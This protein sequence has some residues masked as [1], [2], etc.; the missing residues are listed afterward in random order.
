M[1]DQQHLSSRA[2][3][4]L[5]GLFQAL[6]GITSVI[7]Q[8]VILTRLVVNGDA[9]ATARN[10]QA[11]EVLFRFGFASSLAAVAFHLVW[12]FLFYQLM[13]P[14]NRTLA[15]LATAMI[16]V[17]CA[18]QAVVALLYGAPLAVLQGPHPINGLSEGQLHGLTTVLLNLN[19][20]AFD[21]YLVFFGFWCVPAGYLI[22]RSTFLPRVLGLLLMADGIGYSLFLWPPLAT[23]VFP[24]IAVVSAAA[25]LP[26]IFWLLVYGVN[27][28]RWEKQSRARVSGDEDCP[29]IT[30]GH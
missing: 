17:G 4:R 8:Q 1:S 24:A 5:T 23:L 19:S 21:A 26:L 14:V 30:V 27:S 13:R 2:R 28:Q 12:S 15:A 7:G 11:Q 10:I 22:A 29:A 3:A 25:E 20:Q 16:V 9:A 18:L 6:E